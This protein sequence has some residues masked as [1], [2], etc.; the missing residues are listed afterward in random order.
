MSIND[1]KSTTLKIVL[2]GDYGVGKTSLLN[3]FVFQQFVESGSSTIGVDFYN[4]SLTIAEREINLQVI[5]NILL[6]Y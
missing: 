5:L 3:R 2:L 1:E 4:K 6:L